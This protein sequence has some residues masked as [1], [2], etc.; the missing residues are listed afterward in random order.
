[1]IPAQ[2]FVSPEQSA[3]VRRQI[4]QRPVLALHHVRVKVGRPPHRLAGVVDDEIQP[5]VF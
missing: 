3:R 2:A 4:V 5:L 1:M